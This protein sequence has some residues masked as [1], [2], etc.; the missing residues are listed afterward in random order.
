LKVLSHIY[1]IDS[2]GLTLLGQS[3]FRAKHFINVARPA[4]HDVTRHGM[5]LC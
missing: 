2:I 5:V 3:L 1:G 4:L